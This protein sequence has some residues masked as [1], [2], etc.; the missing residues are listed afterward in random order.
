MAV[1]DG[2]GG[3]G[4]QQHKYYSNMTEAYMASRLCAGAFFDTFQNSFPAT[5][6]R[7][8][9]VD[10][11]ARQCEAACH[12]TLSAFS[13]PQN[14]E[15]LT[16]KGS[17]VRTLPS[18]V[19]AVLVENS[20]GKEKTITALWLGD[21]RC[22]LLTKDGLAQLTIDDTSVYDP[23]ENLYKDGVLRRMLCAGGDIRLHTVELTV[24]GPFSILTATDGCFG[25]LSTPMEFEGVILET[26]LSTKSPLEWEKAL[27]QR[28]NKVAGDDFTLCLAAYGF[29]EFSDMQNYYSGRRIFLQKRYLNELEHLSLDDR[30]ARQK[31]WEIYKTGYLRHYG[32]KG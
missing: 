22:Y 9:L 26:L 13:P 8:T 29:S 27:S 14:D 19:A 30:M 3:A 25:Y 32:G 1:F 5:G 4:A 10:T 17:M 21:S 24:A 12:E 28:L 6:D 15:G 31:M 18:T 7:G 23:M 11:F 2:C 20:V 16:I